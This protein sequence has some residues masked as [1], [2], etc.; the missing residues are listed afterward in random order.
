MTSERLGVASAPRRGRRAAPSCR[1]GV[2][3]ALLA[4]GLV[5]SAGCR[6]ATRGRSL[7]P[8]RP[9]ASASALQ[10]GTPATDPAVEYVA[11]CLESTE[12]RCRSVRVAYTCRLR[13]RVTDG[14]AASCVWAASADAVRF[15]EPHLGERG[16]RRVCV[17]VGDR[18]EM[19]T[20]EPDGAG[21]RTGLVLRGS[22]SRLRQF[23]PFAT[24]ADLALGGMPVSRYIREHGV[25][26]VRSGVRWT[27]RLR[28]SDRSPGEDILVL[29]ADRGYRLERREHRRR[30][31][32]MAVW[33]VT[34]WL[35]AAGD[36][37]FPRSVVGVSWPDVPA[38]R[39]EMHLIVTKADLRFVPPPGYF[40]IRDDRSAAIYDLDAQR[41]VRPAAP[42]PITDTHL[43]R[44]LRY[45][46]TTERE[47]LRASARLDDLAAQLVAKTG[48]TR[49]E[50]VAHM[51]WLLKYGYVDVSM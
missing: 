31:T 39:S 45:L 1:R 36:R 15:E 38:R 13:S 48:H 33:T 20:T 27:V 8:V 40:R 30:G 6:H 26:A 2:T 10:D 18:A 3:L 50:V 44:V 41:L 42:R 28:P 29:R 34:D 19:I 46:R 32:V 11:A 21:G 43:R 14:R 7:A 47:P 9:P 16:K 17:A 5:G 12:D 49:D 23:Y 22:R 35:H 24:W 51:M 37:W 25:G 4:V